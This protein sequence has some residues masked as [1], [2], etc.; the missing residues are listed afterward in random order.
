MDIY[1]SNLSVLRW[2]IKH[3]LKYKRMEQIFFK[4]IKLG[5]YIFLTFYTLTLQFKNIHI[6]LQ[7][8]VRNAFC[9]NFIQVLSKNILSTKSVL[10]SIKSPLISFIAWIFRIFK[11]NFS[12]LKINSFWWKTFITKYQTMLISNWLSPWRLTLQCLPYYLILSFSFLRQKCL[13]DIF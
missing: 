13:T 12:L 7:V 6:N 2:Y 3:A 10:K 9:Q 11:K 8:W 4:I 5:K 1:R